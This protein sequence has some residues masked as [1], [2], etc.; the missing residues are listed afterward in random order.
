MSGTGEN[1][2]PNSGT[3]GAF[4]WDPAMPAEHIDLLKSKGMFDDPVKGTTMLAQSYYEA[5]KALSGGDVLVLPKADDPK[6]GEKLDG[7]FAKTRGVAKFE[8]Y[9]AT[10]PPEAQAH[11]P[12]VDFAKKLAFLWGVPKAKFQDGINEWQKFSAEQK[13]SMETAS[14][15]A[16]DA[17]VTE[18]KT[19]KGE[20]VYNAEI[21][22]GQNVVKALKAKGSISQATL[23]AVEKN[24]GTIA[25]L[26]LL[27]GVGAGMKEGGT[28]GLSTT[29]VAPTDPSQMS[30]EQATAEINRLQ[31]DTEFLA[32]YQT[33]T[34]PEHAAAVERMKLLFEAQ[35]RRPAA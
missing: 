13:A 3:P 22:A 35:A 6:F 24:I 33:A 12:S 20:A 18:F 28:L 32:K 16:N 2:G 34:H 25:L 23:E 1:T 14:K 10:L 21:A 7:V 27:C 11:A 8:E 29:Q 17:A 5:N 15:L 30:K 26:E 19:K 9:E 31:G 4:A